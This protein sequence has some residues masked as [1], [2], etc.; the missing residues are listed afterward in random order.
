MRASE[1]VI[2]A[3]FLILVIAMS[4]ATRAGSKQGSALTELSAR[5][6]AV[7]VAIGIG[8]PVVLI[9]ILYGDRT[10]DSSVAQWI[11]VAIS[12]VG[13]FI[14][15]AAYWNLGPSFSGHTTPN[16]NH[17]LK[18]DGA[19]RIARHP[20]YLG[21]ALFAI[22]ATLVSQRVLVIPFALLFLWQLRKQAVTEEAK[23]TRRYRDRYLAYMNT[24]KR[25]GLF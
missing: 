3:E 7:V 15:L 21:L 9:A 1:I 18:T 8:A 13:M 20:A 11:A 2:V 23:L 17:E 14:T 5:E 4:A 10:F 25:W 24:T 16:V 22:G 12:T 19:H 6:W